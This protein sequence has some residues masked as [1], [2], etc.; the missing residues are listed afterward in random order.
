MS[1]LIASPYTKEH[2][3]CRKILCP[4]H[5]ILKPGGTPFV[6]ERIPALKHFKESDA[7]F[8]GISLW[9]KKKD[10]FGRYIQN[11]K[12]YDQPLVAASYCV[13]NIYQ[14]DNMICKQCQRRCFMK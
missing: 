14:S 9:R 12:D 1:L 7:K 4:R 8:F 3:Y 13:E 2:Q 10:M 6:M 5:Y 11:F